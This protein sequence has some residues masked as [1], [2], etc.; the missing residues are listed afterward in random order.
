MGEPES[1]GWMRG[2]TP[3]LFQA[4]REL[5]SGMTRA[6]SLLWERLR[7]RRLSGLRFRRQHAVGRVVLDFYCPE[8]KL[9]VEVDGGIHDEPVQ[10]EK[11]AER[12]RFLAGL[13]IYVLRVRNEEVE[14]EMDSLLNR[15]LLATQTRR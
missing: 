9:A 3:E 10:A 2:R 8:H 14:S 6:E 4:A 1:G 11:D 7:Q 12:T 5:R 13:G 15:I